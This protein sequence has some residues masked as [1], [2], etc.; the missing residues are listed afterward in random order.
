MDNYRHTLASDQRFQ[1]ARATDQS[2]DRG[3][4]F[5]PETYDPREKPARFLFWIIAGAALVVAL[6]VICASS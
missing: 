3:W 1:A 5:A 6:S 2:G 4:D